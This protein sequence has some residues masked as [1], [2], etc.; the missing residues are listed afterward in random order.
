MAGL[1]KYPKIRNN[2]SFR[3]RSRAIP[4]DVGGKVTE[5]P[6]IANSQGGQLFRRFAPVRPHRSI[7]PLG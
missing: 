3:K 1:L 4:V 5:S 7:D 2:S 6:D